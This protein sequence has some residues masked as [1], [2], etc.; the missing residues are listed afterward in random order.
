[1]DDRGITGVEV[2]RDS[3]QSTG[4]EATEAEA[5]NPCLHSFPVS[6]NTTREQ[7]GKGHVPGIYNSREVR[8][9]DHT[10]AT[11]LGENHENQAIVP[12]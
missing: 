4:Q 7:E 9:S 5:R 3:E 6:S 8:L 2:A 1:M 10:L 11:R 12:N